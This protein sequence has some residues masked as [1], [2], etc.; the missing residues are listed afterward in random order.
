MIKLIFIFFCLPYLSILGN[1]NKSSE[2]NLPSTPVNIKGIGY[3]KHIDIIWDENTET[4]LAGYKV[5][6]KTFDKYI[7]YT[8][9][10]KEKNYLSLNI[11][12]EGITNKFKISAYNNLGEESIL[13]DSIVI[14]T[15]EMTD[16]E[17]LDMTQRATFRYFWNYAHPISG[18]TRERLG[19]EDIVT[20]GGS[21]FGIMAIIVGIEREFIPRI[22]GVER[23]LKILNFLIDKADKFHGAFPHWLNGAT[24][25]VI[26][27]SQYDDG[28]DLVETSFLIQGLLSARQYFNENNSEEEQIRNQI[29]QIWENVEWDWYK[30]S[31][32]STFLYWHWSPTYE[33][34]I[35]FKLIGYN[36]TMITYLLAIASPTHFVSKDFYYKGWSSSTNYFHNQSYYNYKL[37]VGDAYGGPLFF[38]HYSFLGFDPRN[39]RDKYCNYFLNNKHHT[40][41]NRE[42]CISNPQNHIGYDEVT[43]GLTAS[44]NPWGYSA[45]EPYSNDNGTI[46]PTAAISSIPYTPD[47]S[48]AAL[49]NFYRKYYNNLWGEYGFKDAFN[50]DQNW[51]ANS[52]IAI[53]Q[54]PIIIMIENY[55][56]GLLWKNFMANP[57]IKPMLDSVGFVT[58]T[59]T[60]IKNSLIISDKLKLFQNYPNPFNPTTKIKYEIPYPLDRGVKSG[61]LR[62]GRQESNVKLVV[63]DIL[64]RVVKT[65]VNE[66]QQP[67]QY[68]VEFDASSVSQQISSGIYF[69]KIDSDSFTEIKKMVLVR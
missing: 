4:D 30:R 21:G 43:W 62:N 36:E 69:Y 1:A 66:S 8:N 10:P 49:K 37:W 35:N 34:Q 61:T 26:P 17:F 19:S 58:D 60:S 13:S 24:G 53:D 9:I 6:R 44:D 42:Y 7:F 29:T 3:E 27:F 2:A 25:K 48:I 59:L 15:H 45:H 68:E 46:A 51:F 14:T 63:Y 54:G 20:I 18:L 65:L 67:G 56:S 50:L 55:R 40:L 31:T 39:L 33:W 23:I 28:G 11:G 41:I 5:Y 52:Y 16:E 47:E 32:Y 12:V 22:N 38:A 64:G 57:E